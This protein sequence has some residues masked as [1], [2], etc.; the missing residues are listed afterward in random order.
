MKFNCLIDILEEKEYI[1][2][3]SEIANSYW[4]EHPVFNIKT[5]YKE[6]CDKIVEVLKKTCDLVVY[7][8]YLAGN[9]MWCIEYMTLE[10]IVDIQRKI[11]YGQT[12]AFWHRYGNFVKIENALKDEYRFEKI[13][14]NK[15]KIINLERERKER[16]EAEAKA[17]KRQEVRDFIRSLP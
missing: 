11:R 14:E 3:F 13:S 15:Y 9:G 8:V 6:V 17:R 5:E 12:S 10:D 7:S 16:E 2:T 4:N 1:E